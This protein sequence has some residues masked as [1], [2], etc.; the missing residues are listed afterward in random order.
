MKKMVMLLVMMFIFLVFASTAHAE[1]ICERH[2]EYKVSHGYR[3]DVRHDGRDMTFDLEYH[4]GEF[5]DLVVE[6]NGETRN[7]VG[8][9]VRVQ[10]V[11]VHKHEPQVRRV[12]RRV[13]PSSSRIY[14]D[15]L[16]AFTLGALVGGV[17]T[18]DYTIRK[19]KRWK[20]RHYR[21]FR[22]YRYRYPN[23][24]RHRKYRR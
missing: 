22:R 14:S 8:E 19:H 10:K 15:D 16:A 6:E 13:Y 12:C 2:V 20:R 3:V 17:L 4:P 9:V 24:S 11:Y 18:H 21:K 5:M 23:G 1:V 7:V